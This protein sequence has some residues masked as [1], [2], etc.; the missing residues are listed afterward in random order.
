[1][2]PRRLVALGPLADDPYAHRRGRMKTL[3]AG[4]F[5]FE[6][7]GATAGDLQ[8]RDLACA[9]LERA[10]CAY[11]V[12]HAP[13]FRGGV[14]WRRVPPEDYSHVLFV[15]G[16]FG[17]G[18]PLVE[19]LDRFAGR[20]LVGLNL[21]M[22]EPLEAWNPFDRLWER[23]SSACAR[24]DLTFLARQ[25]KAPVVGVILIHPQSEYRGRSRHREANAALR[26]LVAAREVAAV[27]IDTRLDDNGTGLRTPAEVEALIARMD[28]VLTTRLHGL[29]LALKNGVPA[30][31]IDPVAGGHKIT[32]QAEAV[33][34]PLA[35]DVE[36]LAD[37]ALERAFDFCLTAEARAQA[38]RCGE[39]AAAV[40]QAVRDEFLAEFSGVGSR[41]S[42]VGSRE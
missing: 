24:P 19:F 21:S 33:G 37:A 42:G 13:P 31:A 17:N 41:E 39:R 29:A 27:P 40:L 35:F 18:A 23:D 38:R 9:W 4:W 28:A 8:V 2:I 6:Q 5:S 3:V 11:D 12:A 10:G 30:L 1:V 34:W 16:P 15:C 14:D 22:L 32:R 25:P 36:A 26:R 7:M 20:R